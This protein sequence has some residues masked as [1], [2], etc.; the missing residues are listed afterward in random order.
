MS[1][2]NY[3]SDFKDEGDLILI[4][5][6]EV[7]FR[8]HSAILTAASSVFGSMLEIPR[9]ADEQAANTPIPLTEDAVTLTFIL[10]CI[11]PHVA[12]PFRDCLTHTELCDIAEAAD[13]YDV[14]R[15][16]DLLHKFV[17][18]QWD[19]LS[20]QAQS[21]QIYALACRFKWDD[22]IWK[23]SRATLRTNI[24]RADNAPFMRG[25]LGQ[26]DLV[27]LLELHWARKELLFRLV[28]IGRTFSVAWSNSRP[29]H[30]HICPCGSR[31]GVAEKAADKA[32][33]ILRSRVLAYLDEYPL[34]SDLW[35]KRY[36]EQ[37][38]RDLLSITCIDCGTC[39][40][41]VSRILKH[42]ESHDFAMKLAKVEG[43][44]TSKPSP[45]SKS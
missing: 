5:R 22:L 37:E 40:F 18:F 45:T 15:A 31:L 19:A 33:S 1:R 10:R 6:D 16:L 3:H 11:C 35:T 20:A 43:I 29:E 9:D 7:L 28:H 12:L 14:P 34:G 26:D 42:M 8:V 39:V 13:K 25:E 2:P 36:W 38:A 17:H 32:F 44:Y 41:D 23:S 27:T 30:G 24:N 4:S 21:I